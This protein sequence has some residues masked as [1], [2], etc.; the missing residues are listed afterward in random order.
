MEEEIREIVS[1]NYETLDPQAKQEIQNIIAET[2][3]E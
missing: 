1:G 3:G 2:I